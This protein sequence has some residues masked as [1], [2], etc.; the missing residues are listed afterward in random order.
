MILVC[1]SCEAKFNVPDGAIPPEGRTVR[2]AKCKHSWKASPAQLK[3]TPPPAPPRPAAP[4][5]A[6]PAPR[7][8]DPDM[9]AGLAARAAAVR[10]VVSSG[11]DDAPPPP[12]PV[13]E[14]IYDDDGDVRA[15]A[16]MAASRDE[17]L[18]D[19]DDFGVAQALK[20]TLGN[21]FGFD[22]DDDEDAAPAKSG[23]AGTEDDYDEDDFLARRRSEQ[24]RQSERDAKARKRKV[25]TAGWGLLVIFWLVVLYL[26]VFMKEEVIYK[27]PGM[28]GF[29]E[30]FDGVEDI[31]RFREEQTEDGEPL[32]KPLAEEEPYISA[33]LHND[34]TRVETVDGRNTLMVRGFIENTSDRTSATVPKVQVQVLD[35]DGRQ[36]T[37]W[38]VDPPGQIMR[39]KARLNFETSLYPIPSGAANV[40]VD[41][42]KGSRSDAEARSSE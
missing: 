30:M 4:R 34:R 42:I 12:P 27:M 39:R 20:Q 10:N 40:K 36:L 5:P 8:P 33:K 13:D 19:D 41:A 25:L 29:Y 15:P 1:P 17:H 24:R 38:V 28:A 16:P 23:K 18:P 2:C 7:M 6:A 35:K 32:S 3:R 37:S 11:F 22:D 26:L 21:D 31:E 9:D 14:D